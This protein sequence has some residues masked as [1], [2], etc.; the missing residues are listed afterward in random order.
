MKRKSTPELKAPQSSLGTKP[1]PP[2][3][4]KG[5]PSDAIAGR[6]PVSGRFFGL[7]QG[8]A[9]F[10][11]YLSTSVDGASLAVFRIAVGS[12]M[13]LE[14]LSLCRPSA[15]T[16]GRIP[17][18]VFYTAPNV[19]FHFAY[20]GFHWLPVLPPHGI[21]AVVVLLAL[22][23]LMLALGF[24]YRIAALTVFLSWGYLYAIESTRT[25]W[26]S[27]HYLELLVTFLLIW[28]P[29]ARRLSIDA[30][31]ARRKSPKEAL[32]S[33]L[34]RHPLHPSNA[35]P[36]WTLFLLRGQLV[37]AYF[38]AGVAKLNADW[39]LDAQP[40]RYYL[41]QARWINDYGAHLS[42]SVLASLKHL[43][44]SSQMAYLISWAGALFDLS[45]G[46]LFLFRRTRILAMALMLI[47]HGTNH[48][49]IFTDIDWF[50]LLGLLTALI[51]FEPDWPERF[52][53]WLKRPRLSRPDWAWFFAGGI[54]LPVVGAVLGWKVRPNSTPSDVTSHSGPG[55]SGIAPTNRNRARAQGSARNF[56]PAFCTGWLIWQA[57]MPARQYLIPG[58]AR[59]TWEGLSFSWRLKAEVYRCTPC[60][61]FLSDP[62]IISQD[63]SGRSRIDWQKWNGEKVLYRTLQAENVNWSQLPEVFVLLEPMIGQRILYNPFAGVSGGRPEAE[64]RARLGQIW[65]QVYGR[66]P[67]IVLR[68]ASATQA[69]S[70]VAANLRAR[71]YSVQTTLEAEQLFEKLGSQHDERDLTSLL[72][73]TDPLALSGGTAS[74]VPFLLVEDPELSRD[75]GTSRMKVEPNRWARSSF[76]RCARDSMTLN[77]GAEPLVIYTVADP[78][79]LKDQLPSS[80]I[81]DSQDHPERPAFIQ[82][83]YLTELTPGEGMHLSMQPFLLREYA[84]HVADL[85]QERYG[86][87]PAIHAETA[88]S[89]NF[90]PTQPV[91]DPLADLASVPLARL[92]HNRWI[93]DLE[94]PRIPRQGL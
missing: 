83:N 90:R 55:Q 62:A 8:W 2:G 52:W 4:S 40:V 70:A 54:L 66:A 68:T 44:Q 78:F 37:I 56:G 12:I 63:T 1:H 74:P 27:Y 30:W 47:F 79:L 32:S 93:K 73:Q 35:V 5:A 67:K 72:R 14:A 13:A 91:V 84:G 76:T 22:G 19:K 81:F 50:P 41:S 89:L 77:T 48:F 43:L 88:V 31:I 15:S 26:M 21:E 17:L 60:R 80:S 38:Y 82:W 61:F 20:P 3:S 46:F 25:Y 10:C 59:F 34:K 64:S 71:G 6:G 33:S 7:H 53:N 58:D 85:W 75:A 65:Q 28:M 69:L 42:P 23:G 87:R 29:S 24:L 57:L 16:N 45:V 11:A 92:H 86:R 51:F 94:Y 49:L 36:L 39:L 18:E 9:H